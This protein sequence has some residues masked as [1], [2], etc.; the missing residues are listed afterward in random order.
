MPAMGGS[1]GMTS[2]EERLDSYFA[3]CRA[4]V[5]SFAARHFGIAGTLRLHSVAVGL[6]MLRAPFNVLLV[7]PAFFIRLAAMT[8]RALGL[9]GVA[10][11]LARRRLFI[12]T[13]LSRRIAELI[14]VELMAL[15]EAAEDDPKSSAERVEAVLAEYV[16]AR[17][18]V[19]ELAAGAVALIV[20]L[21]TL[22]S[23]TPSAISLGPTLAREYAAADAI[24][25][26]WAGPWAGSIYYS[27]WPTQATWPETIAVT[28]GVMVVFALATTFMGIITD[29]VQQ[30]L[31][32]HERRLHR[33]IDTAERVAKGE[34]DARLELPDPYV[35]RMADLFDGVNIAFRML[36]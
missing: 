12:E 8:C 15:E 19:A 36:R 2:A 29:P 5:T 26:F 33:L 4:R 13:R 9:H 14:L 34:A 27:L 25:G 3:A 6:D 11:W 21:A 20:G 7:G 24:A 18:A 1:V 10:A 35:A 28:L 22:G 23:I 31:G 32:L 16:A 17:H 30:A